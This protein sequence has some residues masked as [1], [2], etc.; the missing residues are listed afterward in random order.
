MVQLGHGF[1]P[2]MRSG[3]RPG[4]PVLQRVRRAAGP[5]EEDEA[6]VRADGRL[7]PFGWLRI[8]AAR[9]RIE[10]ASFKLIGVLP[11][12]RGTGLHARMICAAIEGSRAAGYRRLEASLVDARNEPMR[13]VVEGAGLE[14]Y[15][16]YRIYK[17]LMG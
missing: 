13:K 6:V 15:K 5:A 12:Y 2:G 7:F 8:L 1:L 17:K 16:R 9:R 10:T 3:G 4:R 14:V 11:N